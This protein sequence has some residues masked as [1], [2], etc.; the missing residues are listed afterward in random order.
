MDVDTDIDIN[1][2]MDIDID[3]IYRDIEIDYKIDI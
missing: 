1:I 3:D 2:N